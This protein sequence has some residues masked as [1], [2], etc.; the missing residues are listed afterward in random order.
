MFGLECSNNKCYTED[1]QTLVDL[2]NEQLPINQGVTGRRT[3]TNE[4]ADIVLESG[5]EVNSDKYEMVYNNK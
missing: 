4:Q 5:R 3:L 2:L 1:Q